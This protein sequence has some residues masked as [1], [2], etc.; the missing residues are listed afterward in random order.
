LKEDW[1]VC[2]V[3]LVIKHHSFTPPL[4][5]RLQAVFIPTGFPHLFVFREDDF[6]NSE[7]VGIRSQW[8]ARCFAAYLRTHTH[9]HRWVHAQACTRFHTYHDLLAQV[10][11]NMLF[12]FYP[13]PNCDVLR[14]DRS[15][16]RTFHASIV[17]TTV[18]FFG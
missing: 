4:Y 1:A 18:G 3:E 7:I 11:P 13:N 8:T 9:T 10:F 15:S 5:A 16:L 6:Q 2:P 14:H 17:R 12:I